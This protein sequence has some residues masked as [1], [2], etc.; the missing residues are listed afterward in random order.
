MLIV[1][2]GRDTI[3]NVC[4]R[5]WDPK[6]R[7]V[8]SAQ[9]HAEQMAHTEDELGGMGQGRLFRGA[10]SQLFRLCPYTETTNTLSFTM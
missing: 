9:K 7:T 2:A 10:G 3:K 6:G 8:L 1:A 4:K 5:F